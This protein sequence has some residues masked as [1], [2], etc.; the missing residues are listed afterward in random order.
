MSL[1]CETVWKRPHCRKDRWASRV[2]SDWGK[3]RL[4]A[5][6]TPTVVYL[7]YRV[8]EFPE[9]RSLQSEK[10]GVDLKH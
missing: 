7:L 1:S 6:A 2:Q 10:Y 4:E 3:T 8:L 5:A 9:G